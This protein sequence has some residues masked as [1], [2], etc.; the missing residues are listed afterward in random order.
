MKKILF[1]C[2]A[3]FVIGVSV[4]HSQNKKYKTKMENKIA[5]IGN[6]F[7]ADFGQMAFQLHFE[8]P[9]QMTFAPILPDGLGGSET[10]K[11]TMVEIRPNVYMVYW[12]EKSGFTITH[13]EDFEKGIVYTNITMTD[14][15]FVNLKGKLTK[16]NN[17]IMDNKQK[18][19]ALLKSLE[20][21]ATEPVGYINPN[22]YIQHNL[23]VGDGLAGFGAVL[24]ALPPNSAKAKIVRVFEDGDFVFAHT[25]YN[26]FGPK[27]GFDIFRFENGKIV[28]HWD[29]LQETAKPNP[30]GRTM[31]DG[32]TEVK[33][34]DKTEANK[35]L[36]KNCVEDI[37]VNGKMEK[38][39]GYY[40]GDNYIQHNPVVAD[41]LSGLGKVLSEWAKQGII[42]KYDKIHKVLGEGNF[43]LVVSEG[44]LGGK[45]NSFYDLFRIENGKIAEHWDTI[46]EIP[47]KETWKNNNGKF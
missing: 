39:A 43:V 11:T 28:E 47:A 29:N 4:A 27:I 26:F 16:L 2:T 7:K 15:S 30:S 23:A 46:E 13:L 20:T 38:L 36:V 19:V 35:A 24:Q 22:K 12:K 41:G 42:M 25:D 18:V 14:H 10:V 44:S 17:K 45:H 1:V 40:D 3:L 37:L 21:G 32:T 31:I 34:F 6:T 33:D 5:V 9:T 8:S